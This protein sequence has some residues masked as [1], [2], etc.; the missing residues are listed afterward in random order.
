M[1]H[2]I[3]LATLASALSS[4]TASAEH[5]KPVMEIRYGSEVAAPTQ[6]VE[7]W[8]AGAYTIKSYDAAG[9]L[10]NTL[11]AGFTNPEMGE[12]RDALR[13]AS[14]KVTYSKI[15]CFAYSPSFTEY[16]VK[17]KLVY[18]AQMCSGATAD[19]VTLQ[20]IATIEKLI[21]GSK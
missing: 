2:L 17:G 7:I 11:R 15:A 13:T 21:A 1:K 8:S 3:V 9:A 16:Y 5:A 18:R 10:T 4:Q 19:D 12:V 6:T 14:W 20:S